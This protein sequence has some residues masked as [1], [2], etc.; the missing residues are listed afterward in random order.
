MRNLPIIIWLSLIKYDTIRNKALEAFNYNF[1]DIKYRKVFSIEEA[2]ENAFSWTRAID[3]DEYWDDVYS[4]PIPLREPLKFDNTVVNVTTREQW[5]IVTAYYEYKWS[6]G[7]AF[8][9]YDVNSC[10]NLS[11]ELYGYKNY[12]MSDE[13]IVL[14][15]DEWLSKIGAVK[16]IGSS[17]KTQPKP[18]FEVGDT[19]KIV[20]MKG[21]LNPILKIGDEFVIEEMYPYSD[22]ILFWLRDKKGIPDGVLETSVELVSK[23]LNNKEN[24]KENRSE[25]ANSMEDREQRGKT[26]EYPIK[27]SRD[28]IQ[29]GLIGSGKRVE[30]SRS[31]SKSIR[32]EIRSGYTTKGNSVERSSY[33]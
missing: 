1:A 24:V 8:D 5:D 11:T 23:N 14:S 30:Q 31:K 2:I 19:V 32:I 4:N 28:T 9:N 7:D 15:Y 16:P 10:I 26:V 17:S 18:K 29:S 21:N 25:V 13:Y 33:S 6:N 20:S 22:N 3:G 12:Y 27:G